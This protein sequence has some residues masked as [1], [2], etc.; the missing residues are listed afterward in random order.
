METLTAMKMRKSCRSFTDEMISD[1]DVKVLIE[2]GSSASVGLADYKS[3]KITVIQN[4]QILDDI[5]EAIKV[6]YNTPNANHLYNATTLIMVSA[7]PN[8]RF[9]GLEVQNCAS[10]CEH[11]H[12]M[13]SD[14]K[15]ASVYVASFVPIVNN[16]KAIA[17]KVGLPEGHSAVCGLLVGYP[18]KD[19]AVLRDFTGKIEVQ[20]IK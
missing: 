19:D 13:A 8:E 4:K 7:K 18:T 14:L 2:A 20:T 10:V 17:E 12:I 16:N 6:A 11:M 5:S 15:L 9:P 1:D 3:M